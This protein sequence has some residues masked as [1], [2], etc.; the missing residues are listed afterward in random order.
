MNIVQHNS[1]RELEKDVN[2]NNDTANATQ[3]KLC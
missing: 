2:F 3:L 1:G